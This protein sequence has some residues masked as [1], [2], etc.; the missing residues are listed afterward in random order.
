[1]KTATANKYTPEQQKQIA[2]TIL[3]QLGGRRFTAMTGAKNFLYGDGWLRMDLRKNQSKANRL[4][5]TYN[6]GSDSYT[7]K[8]YKFTISRKTFDWKET[9]V[10]IFEDVYADMLQDIFTDVTGMYTKL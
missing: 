9:H 4:E 7:V 2:A 8:F 5:I 10:Q 3:T 1:M 6:G